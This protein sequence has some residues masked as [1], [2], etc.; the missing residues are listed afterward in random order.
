MFEE[1]KA[2]LND[3]PN[4]YWF[5]AKLYGWGWTP[6]KWQGWAV[7]LIFV[8]LIVL[9]AFRLDYLE[10]SDREVL[11][12]FIPQTFFLVAILIYVCYKKG[13]R[14]RWQWGPPKKYRNKK[15]DF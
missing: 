14:P 3:N 7:I 5:K 1:Y 2:Y 12:T 10:Y 4:G 8:L 9:N 6:V 11:V 15:N 13:E